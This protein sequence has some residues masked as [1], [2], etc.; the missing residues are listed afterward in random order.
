MLFDQ[1]DFLCYALAQKHK[2]PQSRKS[3]WSSPIL[4]SGGDTIGR[5]MTKKEIREAII[6]EPYPGSNK[7]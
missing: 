3:L 2:D 5:I 7:I 6:N 1:A 4:E